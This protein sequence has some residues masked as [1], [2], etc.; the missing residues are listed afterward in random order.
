MQATLYNTLQHSYNLIEVVI[1]IIP[2]TGIAITFSMRILNQRVLK[3]IRIKLCG[4]RETQSSLITSQPERE[5]PHG[6]FTP[7]ILTVSV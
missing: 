7:S 4:I 1:T 5:M 2:F 3:H 6:K